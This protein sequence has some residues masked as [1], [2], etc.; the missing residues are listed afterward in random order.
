MNRSK[1]PAWGI[2]GI[3]G[4]IY[5]DSQTSRL[6]IYAFKKEAQKVLKNGYFPEK[7]KIVQI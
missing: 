2:I 3:E 1:K 6:H 5:M 7:S 4:F